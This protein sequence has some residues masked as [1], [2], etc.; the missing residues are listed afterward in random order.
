M[1]K[2]VGI[3]AK[4]NKPEAIEASRSL[5]K[6]LTSQGLEVILDDHLLKK[7]KGNWQPIS[8]AH[9]AK[10]GLVI[11]LGGDGTFLGAARLIKNDN[12]PVL[13]VNLGGLGF[14]TDF[15]LQELFPVLE[16]ILA[17]RF[18]TEKRMMLTSTIT[19]KDKILAEYSVLNDVVITKA[20][21]SRIIDLETAINKHYLTTFKADGLI[22]S[23]PTGS[24]AYSM[25]AGG[26]I[27][28]P[29][30]E[31]IILTPICPHT[32]TNRPI[33]VPD[34]AEIT[35]AIKS[36]KENIFLTFDGQVGQ[37]LKAGDVV[38]IKKDHFLTMIKSPFKDYFEVLRTKLRWGER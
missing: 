37:S 35:I 23:T 30:L 15:P 14:L 6:W 19:R 24:T 13:G 27:V 25:A 8:Q 10:L 22:I 12:I 7:V 31:A 4:K 18:K 3:I 9:L 16:K 29:S 34:S 38:T 5:I 28:F 20:A 26:P 36:P 21:I 33:L 11:V 17:G 32:L 1:I 2:Q